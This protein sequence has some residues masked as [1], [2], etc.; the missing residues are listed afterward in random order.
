M[1]DKSEKIIESMGELA[2]KSLPPDLYEKWEEI[3]KYY[4]L[5]DSDRVK[6]KYWTQET[7][8]FGRWVETDKMPIEQANDSLENYERGEIIKSV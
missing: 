7:A 8:E 5:K 1:N 3:K 6:I 2:I 4:N